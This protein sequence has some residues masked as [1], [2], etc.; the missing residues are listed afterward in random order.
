MG[1]VRWLLGMSVVFACFC[2]AATPL[3][4]GT[5]NVSVPEPI[6]VGDHASL[7]LTLH[8]PDGAKGPVLVTPRTQGSAVE[9]VRGRLLKSD[10]KDPGADPL[11]FELPMLARSAG[12]AVVSVRA[13]VYRC[14]DAECDALTLEAR[15]NVLVLPRL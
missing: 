8:L 14:D 4:R 13:L 9:V 11:V 7:T 12:Q 2:L 6:H 5:L 1:R 15:K 10:A 3:D